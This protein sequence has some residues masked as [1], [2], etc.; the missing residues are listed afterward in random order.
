[1]T[2]AD[3]QFAISVFYHELINDPIWDELLQKGINILMNKIIDHSMYPLLEQ[4]SMKEFCENIKPIC[5]LDTKHLE[6]IIEGIRDDASFDVI[7]D[8]Y[9]VVLDAK[10][11]A[12]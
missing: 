4:I 10:E 7:N 2:T 12:K 9:K 6:M 3:K 5:K 8:V 11:K 1:M